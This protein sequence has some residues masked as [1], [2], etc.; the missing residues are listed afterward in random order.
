MLIVKKGDALRRLSKGLLPFVLIVGAL[1]I[2]VYVEPDL[3]TAMFY[4]L[5]M[6]II[7]LRRR[8]PDRTFRGHGDCR[9]SA[10]IH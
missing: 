9:H 4:T 7:L 1:D 10:P 3:S 2:L 5:I 6:G 8:C